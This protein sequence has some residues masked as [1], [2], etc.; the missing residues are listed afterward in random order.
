VIGDEV[1]PAAVD[2]RKMEYK[3]DVRLNQQAYELPRAAAE[4]D[5]ETARADARP[6]P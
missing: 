4:V 5:R 1:L 2:I 3:L 6:R